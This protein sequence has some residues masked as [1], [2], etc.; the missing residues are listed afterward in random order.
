MMQRL[1]D[2]DDDAGVRR[3][4]AEPMGGDASCDG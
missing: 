2:G 4:A 1:R 3:I